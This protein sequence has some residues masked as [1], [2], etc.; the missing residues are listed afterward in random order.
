MFRTFFPNP[1]V[2]FLSAVAWTALAMLVW[3]TDPMADVQP[4][5]ALA[6]VLAVNFAQLALLVLSLRLWVTTP[7]AVARPRWWLPAIA[8]V[9]ALETAVGVAFPVIVHG[10]PTMQ[11]SVFFGLWVTWV[12]CPWIRT[13]L[14]L[15]GTQHQALEHAWLLAVEL[16]V[17]CLCALRNAR[18]SARGARCSRLAPAVL[19]C[20]FAA[21]KFLRAE[22][23]TRRLLLDTDEDPE[24]AGFGSSSRKRGSVSPTGCV[25]RLLGR[26]IPVEFGSG[27]GHDEPLRTRP[28]AHDCSTFCRQP[29]PLMVVLSCSHSSACLILA[30]MSA[31][32]SDFDM[33][34][35]MGR[36]ASSAATIAACKP[37]A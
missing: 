35:G 22:L 6:L 15:K 31:A 12:V 3:F 11:Y 8:T 5:T 2:F 19:C 10:R 21:S 20:G 13:L 26:R 32:P 37:A 16:R 7:G 9:L 33:G 17:V 18:L 4:D 28:P 36:S 1:R 34:G 29:S 25:D 24:S 23:P 14:V 27:A 30:V